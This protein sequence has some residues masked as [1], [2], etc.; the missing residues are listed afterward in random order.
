[1]TLMFLALLEIFKSRV[2][3]LSFRIAHC[4]ENFWKLVASWISW[5][6]TISF[7][8]LNTTFHIYLPL[9]KG[10]L[11]VLLILIFYFIFR[12]PLTHSE[13]YRLILNVC[14]LDVEVVRYETASSFFPHR[15]W[16][17]IFEL[18][19][20]RSKGSFSRHRGLVVGTPASYSVSPRY[21]SLSEDKV[22]S[23]GSSWI[24]EFLQRNYEI[25][26]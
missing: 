21:G 23:W 8:Y 15:C 22:S 9:T 5:K 26:P 2:L 1:M 14:L 19:F 13:T 4:R 6:W 11:I 16:T 12:V 25:S 18:Y 7:R 3:V 24:L 10:F 17:P 20:S